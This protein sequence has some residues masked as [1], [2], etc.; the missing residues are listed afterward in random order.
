MDKIITAV[1]TY[2][3]TLFAKFERGEL[4]LPFF[5]RR[6]KVK[7]LIVMDN[8]GGFL[9]GSFNTSYFGLSKVLD[10]LRD[11][12]DY[13]V[14]FDVKRAHRSLDPFKPPVADVTATAHYAPHYENFRFTGAT[15]PADFNLDDYNQVWFFGLDSFGAGLDNNELDVIAKWMD[16]KK[17][18]VFAVGDAADKVYRQA[19]TAA[20]TGC[21][22]ALDAEKF[23]AA[24]EA[25]VVH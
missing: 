4:L 18:G 14:E 3:D 2:R 5:L 21:M 17:G 11:E 10:T 22:G 13:Y 23:L 15:K 6:A 20:G 19:I 24:K 16:E 8:S 7:I 1:P 12:A 9:S 25:E